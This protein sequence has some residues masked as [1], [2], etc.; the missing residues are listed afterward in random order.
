MT[1]LRATRLLHHGRTR[2]GGK[3]TSQDHRIPKG[4]PSVR[5]ISA[6]LEFH[7]SQILEKLAWACRA[8]PKCWTRRLVLL[9]LLLGLWQI[10]TRV[11][12]CTQGRLRAAISF[13]WMEIK[14]EKHSTTTRLLCQFL[15]CAH[16]CLLASTTTSFSPPF[17]WGEAAPRA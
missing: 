1:S 15:S 5:E 2:W 6:W 7:P 10:H 8:G 12:L 11:L 4:H 13:T 17:L 3:T 9:S 14:E 16:F